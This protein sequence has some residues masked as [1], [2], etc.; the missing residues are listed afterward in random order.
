[1]N[2]IYNIIII[3]YFNCDIMKKTS[4]LMKQKLFSGAVF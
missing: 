3:I 4:I 1:M 2:I